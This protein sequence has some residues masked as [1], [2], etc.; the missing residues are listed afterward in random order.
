MYAFQSLRDLHHAVFCESY[1]ESIWE[2]YA[3]AWLRRGVRAFFVKKVQGNLQI[4]I[5]SWIVSGWDMLG[6]S[7]LWI[8][9]DLMEE[10]T[11]GGGGGKGSGDIMGQ[12]GHSDADV[13]MDV[14]DILDIDGSGDEL[15]I[16]LSDND[17]DDGMSAYPDVGDIDLISDDGIEVDID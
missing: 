12:D 8:D 10:N 15:E 2:K 16:G 11:D 3:P 9:S 1:Y 5:G 7:S 13:D 14:E 17:I 4:V 6:F